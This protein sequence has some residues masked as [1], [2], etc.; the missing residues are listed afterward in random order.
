MVAASVSHRV[1][2]DDSD[3]QT[4]VVAG[5]QTTALVFEPQAEKAVHVEEEKTDMAPPENE[6]R[7]AAPAV[8]ETRPEDTA[9]RKLKIAG[10]ATL[11]AGAAFLVAGAVT[12]GLAISVNKDIERNCPDGCYA[13]EYDELDR[14]NNLALATDVLIGVG[15]G[16]TIA[17][18][19]LV[20]LAILK[21]RRAES[22]ARFP[23]V[24]PRTGGAAVEWRF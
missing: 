19:A 22:A 1:R 17:G 9:T 14:R 3:D 7:E 11:G 2:A 4:V 13:D 23:T 21:K 12:G 6:T 24:L 8:V 5:G 16:A 20:V 10:F 15:A 18:T